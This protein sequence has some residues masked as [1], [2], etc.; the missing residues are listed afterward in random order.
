[1]I[2]LLY[3]AVINGNNNQVLIDALRKKYDAI[4]IDEF[5]DTDREQYAVFEKLFNVDK[6]LFY[7]GDPKQSIYAFRKADIFTY[8]TAANSVQNLHKMNTNHR[9]T[10]EYID[11]MNE[12]FEPVSGFDT[13]Y[14]NNDPIIPNAIQYI[15]VSSPQPN[16]KGRL[17]YQG[18]PIKPIKISRHDNKKE[19]RRGFAGIII[20]LLT[21]G[22]YSIEKNSQT[23]NIKPSDI[24]I[25]VRTKKEAV[26]I[27][28]I[29][30][31]FR[32][33]AVTIDDTRLLESEEAKQLFYIMDAVN[34]ISRA[35]INRALLT[36]LG[37][38]SQIELLDADEEA[39]LL[40]FRT[41]Q[42]SWKSK[43]IYLMLRQFLADHRV[44][45]RLYNQDSNNPER[46]I[47]NIQQ[48]VEIIHK[49][50]ER[51]NYEPKELIQWLKK[52][53][54]GDTREGDEYEQRIESDDEAVKIV[55]IHKS[56]GLEY[57]IVIAPH[58]DL[59][60]D[61]NFY[62]TGSYRSP[63][64][65]NY[66]ISNKPLPTVENGWYLAQSE[67]E[68]RRLLYVAITRARYQ[69]F[70]T[71]SNARNYSRSSLRTF[72]TALTQVQHVEFWVPPSPNDN[73]TYAIQQAQGPEY[74]VAQDFKLVQ[75]N[76]IKTSY[77]GLNP[78][79]TN[80][81]TPKS[82]AK[83]TNSYDQFVFQDLKRGAYTGNLLH[84]IFEHI[85]FTNS[86]NWPR[87]VAQ[88]LK[89]LSSNSK[90]AYAANIVELLHQVT[91]LV[92]P[93]TDFSLNQITKSKR[94]NELEFDFLMKPFNT[95][96]L[97]NISSPEHPFRIRSIAELEGI[98]NGK[99]DLFFEHNGKYYILDWKSNFLGNTL[100]D[101]NADKVKVA[102]YENNY[103][104]QYLIYTVALTK[105]L[106]LR[107][108]DFA[109]EIDFG[110]VIY[111]F[112]RGVRSGVET[113]F[114]FNKPNWI[115]IEKIKF[116]ISES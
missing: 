110:G 31:A 76:W 70:I 48:L 13:F 20:E 44:N 75:S 18:A 95:S 43:G 63:V 24:G 56:K 87:I 49:V 28:S 59:L 58:L 84:H 72:C 61:N 26:G 60:P 38:Y 68:N 9:S 77:S 82:Q 23:R 114:Y 16:L 115:T 92:I 27:K 11:A 109:Y 51:K 108:P 5:Q 113:G 116:I 2:L 15:P 79:H 30:A 78:E 8:F 96:A 17:L 10:E 22:N 37:G 40:Q 41:Y 64:D 100:G 67:Q 55:T 85:D 86:A 29:L 47:A 25:L 7:I 19:L 57:N 71:A 14:F 102:M 3:N 39:V 32:I 98:M 12:F 74:A 4:F 46:T 111:L 88:A 90:E 34:D 73:F 80:L 50:A 99:M 106:S 62:T 97:E 6:I 45:E 21:P 42:E 54:E 103:H 104:L 1:M 105:F 53:M 94:L 83:F 66:Y 52:G 89:R 107:K 33:P 81:L 101:Y 65:G 93:G 91:S 36:N 112:L 69:C 35:T